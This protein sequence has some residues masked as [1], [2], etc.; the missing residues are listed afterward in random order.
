MTRPLVLAALLVAGAC[1]S[2]PPDPAGPDAS[3]AGRDAAAKV[4]AGPKVETIC[5]NGVDD[6]GDGLTDCDDPDCSTSP[7][8]KPCNRQQNCGD[9]VNEVTTPCCITQPSG[10]AKCSPPGQSTPEGDP[11][12][13]Q[14]LFDLDFKSTLTGSLKPMSVILR[15]VYPNKVDGSPISC[16]DV[17]GSVAANTKN[18]IDQT[19]RSFIDDNPALNQ[20]FRSVYPLDWTACASTE[21]YFS[22]MIATIP[23]G[24]K[25]I[26]YGEA[27]YG[28][29]ELNEPTGLCAAFYCLENQT[30]SDDNTHY[31]V[32]FK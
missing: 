23:K 6:D 8:C 31:L 26:L 24:Q 10:S 9:I 12:T 29:R 1:G 13:A 21:C 4:D 3:A 11:V 22:N 7:A 30:V 16:T 5:A 32:V 28:K 15:F 14:V 27:W 19:T 25:Y 2:P 17:V 20:V 18:C